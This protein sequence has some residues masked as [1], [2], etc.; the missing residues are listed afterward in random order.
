MF[1][2]LKMH[3]AGGLDDVLFRE[4]CPLTTRGKICSGVVV[5]VTRTLLFHEHRVCGGAPP[6]GSTG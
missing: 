3:S 4:S 5:R 2:R 1:A 6:A